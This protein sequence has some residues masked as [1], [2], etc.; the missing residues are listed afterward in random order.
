MKI[1]LMLGLSIFLAACGPSKYIAEEYP[2]DNQKVPAFDVRGEVDVANGYAESKPTNVFG[3]K[4]SGDLKQITEVFAG[5]LQKEIEQN[6]NRGS[7]PAKH[8]KARVTGISGHNRFVYLEGAV[9][10]ELTLGNGETVTFHKKNGSPANI[11]RALNGALNKAVIETLSN[12][13]VKAY[14]AE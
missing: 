7:G 13:T 8:I 3:N 6:G 9:D 14:L 12:P 1:W 10:I 11:W 5:Q 2:V 4:M